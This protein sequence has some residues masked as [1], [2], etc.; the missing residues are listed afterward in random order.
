MSAAAQGKTEICQYLLAHGAAVDQV[1]QSGASA[2][3]YALGSGHLNVTLALLEHH[4]D[5]NLATLATP[6]FLEKEAEKLTA[7]KTTATDKEKEKEE[8]H[9]D[10]VTPLMVAAEGGFVQLVQVLLDAGADVSAVD[11]EDSTALQYAVREGHLTLVQVLVQH[12]ANPNEEVVDKADKKHNLLL[13]AIQGND[14]DLSVLLV[15]RGANVSVSDDDGVSALIQ[16]AYLGHDT[17]VQALLAHGADIAH[18]NN[19]GITA[20]V[21]AASE[22]HN[23]VVQRLLVAVGVVVVLSP[24]S[25]SSFVHSFFLTLFP[26]SFCCC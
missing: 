2:L 5:V 3:L 17:V 23:T 7:S 10:G 1:S 13:D 12:G 16:A 15:N 9:R 6:E 25:F 4:A 8:A 14:V 11:D 22:G 19:E 24:L 26:L 18:V 21:A 20:L